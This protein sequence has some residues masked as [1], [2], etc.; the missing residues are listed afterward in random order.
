MASITTTMRLVKRLAVAGL[1]VLGVSGSVVAGVDEAGA[2]YK[3]GDYKR[4]YK[5]FRLLALDGNA[6]AQSNLG[7][8][9][10]EGRGVPQDYAESVKWYE[11]AATQGHANGQ[12]GLGFMY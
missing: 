12:F 7:F 2:A 1:L 11:K 8:M 4:A 10:L 9:Y 5:E 6:E 3:R